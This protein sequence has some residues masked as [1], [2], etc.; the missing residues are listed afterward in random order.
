MK[1]NGAE[2]YTANITQGKVI[3]HLNLRMFL[4]AV[5][6]Y[7]DYRYN[8]SSYTFPID[9]E[10][11]HFFSQF[12]FSYKL[13]PRTVLFLGY[14]DNARGTQDYRLTRSDRA[15]FMKVSYSWQI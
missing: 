15:I 4:R 12:L 9:P 8:V 3:Y 1:V 10:F 14:S 6:Q 5:A 11:R 2:L 7:V 13:N